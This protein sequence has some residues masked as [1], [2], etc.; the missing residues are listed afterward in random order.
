MPAICFHGTSGRPSFVAFTRD[1][2]EH[3]EV[4]RPVLRGYAEDVVT[5]RLQVHGAIEIFI[6]AGGGRS[7]A[8]S[9]A[10][11]RCVSW[12]RGDA[13]ERPGC[14]RVSAEEKIAAL[15]IRVKCQVPRLP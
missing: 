1:G 12:R 13:R 3:A 5:L 9:T 7:I 4:A 8:P 6:V 14:G 10:T 2:T 15:Q 11:I